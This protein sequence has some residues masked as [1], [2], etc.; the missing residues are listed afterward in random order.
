MAI[1]S[2]LGTAI[3]GA[4]FAGSTLAASV[5]AGGLA[6]AA[7][8]G[9]SYL[10]RPKKRSYSA[11]Q[12]ETQF[13]GDVPVGTIYG[14][15][16]TK[17]Q[18]TF[19][20]KWGAGNKCN[21]EVFLLANGWC[22][23][24]EP[25][26]YFYGQKQTL[27]ERPIIGNEVAHYGVEGFLAGGNHL[28]SIRFYDGRPDQL[29]DQKLVD[30]TA[31]LGPTWK[32]T[33]VNAGIAYVVVERIF[34]P[35]QFDKG[36]PDIEFVVR[37]LREYDP[38]KDSTVAGGSGPQRL[39][40]PATWVHTLNPAVHRF[41][42]QLGLRALVSGRTLIG[43]GKSIGQLDLATYFVAMNVCDTLR[44]DDKPTYQC[45]LVVGG[46]DDHTEILREFDDA[47][48]GYGLNRRGLSGVIAG[49]PQIPVMEITA[50][51]IPADRAKQVQY[52][53][54]AFELYNHMSGQFTS[55]EA[56][57]NPESL[58][59][60]Y[61]NADIAA[62]GRNRQ[63]SNDF[64][65]VTD[66]D[67]AQY[68]LNIRYRQNR[69]GGTATLPVS[70]RVGLKVQEGEWVSWR[71]KEWMISEW[72]LDDRFQ[73]T[74]KLTETGADI[75][76]DEAIEPGP[77]VIPPTAPL[78]PSLLSTVQKLGV[79][80]GLLTGPDG[81]EYPTLQFTWTPPDD[82]SIV[83]VRFEYFDGVD[84]TDKTIQKWRCDQP[85]DGTDE[86]G[87][88]IVPGSPY[89]AR[90]TIV[91]Q[92]D[93]LKTWTP[94]VTTAGSTAPVY[95]PGMLE[96]LNER[97]DE[98]EEFIGA[99][100]DALEVEIDQVT[101]A[102][103]AET[104]ARTD[105]V[106]AEQEERIADARRLAVNYR[107]LIDEVGAVRD[108]LANAS[109]TGFTHVE[110]I[111]TALAVRVND[112]YAEFDQRVTVATGEN[113]GMVQR[114]TRLETGNTELTAL[115]GFVETASVD[116]LNAMA[117]QISLLSAGT[118]NQFD[119][120]V[121][122]NFTSTIES[123]TG[124]GTPTWVAG[125]IRPAN[126]V[127]GPYITSPTALA[128]VA[129]TYRQVR[130]RIRKAGSPTWVGYCWWKATSDTTWDSARRVSVAEPIFDGNGFANITFYLE[131]TGTIDA[132]RL[133]ISAAQTA[134][135]YYLIDWVG[136]G[137]PSP[138]A[139]R[140]ELL[141]ERTARISADDA[142]V[143]D[144][145]VLQAAINSPTTGLGALS[146][147]VTGVTARVALTE[148]GI[149][150]HGDILASL[151]TE[152]D[153]KA[154][155]ETVQ[156]IQNNIDAL[157]AG[158][159]SS[160][161]SAVTTI[162]NELLA[163]A[164]QLMEL[165]FQNFLGQI[166]NKK[167]IADAAQTLTTRIELTNDNL[168][169]TSTALTKVQ[170]EIPNLAKSTAVSI[171]DT[172]IT[173]NE[174]LTAASSVAIDRVK[175]DL[176]W[177]DSAATGARATALNVIRADVSLSYGLAGAKNKTYRQNTAPIGTTAVPLVV[178][179]LWVN[180]SDGE[181]MKRWN[182]TAWI[183]VTDAR[184]TS[185]ASA[186]TSIKAELGWD[187]ASPSGGKATAL[188]LLTANVTVAYNLADAKNKVYRQSGAPGGTT[189]VPL[190]NGDIWINS[191][192]GEVTKRWNG[193]TWIDVTDARVTS[194]ASAITLIKSELGWDD[195]Q[196]SGGKAT[197]LS[198]VRTD[199]SNVVALADSKNR[200]Y[201]QINPPTGTT[202]NPLRSGDV[203]YASGNGNMPNRWNGSDWVPVDD[204]R[205]QATATLL[206][207]LT[208]T[209]D[210]NS[211]NAR[212][213]MSTVA[214]PT[215]YARIAARVKYTSSGLERSAGFYVDVPSDTSLDSV[216]LVEADQFAVRNGSNKK[217]PF[218]VQGGEVI[219]DVANIGTVN[220]GVL[221]SLNGKMRIDLNAGTIRISS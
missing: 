164:G 147:A 204:A 128:I 100:V 160:I 220:A 131:W 31:A 20:G 141:A 32:S 112:I 212:F 34:K 129:T 57:W 40:D 42:Y 91:T 78:N 150:A 39:D 56:M 24:L 111:R 218:I 94:W 26:V 187:E 98:F 205:V 75:Y 101:A 110:Q 157:D 207:S 154:S 6:F 47:M 219:M 172:R 162:R 216:F 54:S 33:S 201:R 179:D 181:I 82:P 46:E 211:A 64:L 161:G 145:T 149:T 142:Q 58:K 163:M 106:I 113:S 19:Y 17:G 62:D 2:F 114:I 123:W 93:R 130:A 38:R 215:G 55:I 148:A 158:G 136:I 169:V 217:K 122:W 37:G 96:E 73:I 76:D 209:V 4:L 14:T 88:N 198:V 8:I 167:I 72:A 124:N 208:A 151:E 127:S 133:D 182:G 155:I 210:D 83:A 95:L 99:D 159:V 139:S 197:G 70:R 59:P 171:L 109:Y 192:D 7:R 79:A 165:G 18:R 67:I 35:E 63:V 118:D 153:G 85:E 152:I 66:P 119:P 97:F 52:R 21:A 191:A 135:D 89:S 80:V 125:S 184:I 1:F 16:K 120:A 104:E 50:D 108:L 188:T 84:P 60:V 195:A 190:R 65:Q 49:A 221:Q 144:I 177:D 185:S 103:I 92:P 170:A 140:A 146:T 10:N 199:V 77:I 115:I 183:D 200:V 30:D 116:G 29:V 9:L 53:K 174:L 27:V 213:K 12:A 206:Q 121:M 175:A 117:Q 176:G 69:K 11:V 102:L 36:K 68:L 143:T 41:N 189:A 48:A 45:S 132:I 137:S 168:L 3:A 180:S 86:T 202:A 25:Y 22:D 23:G 173:A 156:A 134:S 43:E 203:W 107:A 71:G 166:E 138:G 214:G 15:S 105:Q 186:L 51:D 13:G 81:T 44:L 28:F 5:I 87:T 196:P 74:L 61:V 126:Q 90:A 193:S 194:S 178:G